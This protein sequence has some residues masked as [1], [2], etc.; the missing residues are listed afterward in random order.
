MPTVVLPEPATPLSNI[1]GACS[2]S[3][4]FCCSG[5]CRF[6]IK[7]LILPSQNPSKRS[8]VVR[9]SK[10]EESYMTEARSGEV[11]N[12]SNH[13]RVRSDSSDSSSTFSIEDALRTLCTKYVG[14]PSTRKCV[15]WK[16]AKAFDEPEGSTS[17]AWECSG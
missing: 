11:L 14:T 5:A 8:S 6:S 17:S 16:K 3:T 12:S 4:Y 2:I 1:R 9:K 7:R 15:V 13:K 10:R